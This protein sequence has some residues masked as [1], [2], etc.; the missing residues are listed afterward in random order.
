M[1][2]LIKDLLNKRPTQILD[3]VLVPAK[4][5]LKAIH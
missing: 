5:L 2:S 4:D 3:G 1:D